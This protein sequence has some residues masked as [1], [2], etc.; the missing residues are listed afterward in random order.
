MPA[1]RRSLLS[2]RKKK[3]LLPLLLLPSWGLFRTRF[4]RRTDME[5]V[6]FPISNEKVVIFN[7]TLSKSKLLK[8]NQP[9]VTTILQPLI[10]YEPSP[11]E[12]TREAT[13]NQKSSH[14]RHRP[15]MRQHP[16]LFEISNA[17]S[18]ADPPPAPTSIESTHSSTFIRR[19]LKILAPSS[20]RP[21]DN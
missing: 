20:S 8:T 5:K 17:L 7:E 21:I 13:N 15:E 11:P 10:G 2:S 19:G 3:T 6:C 9:T 4:I 12:Q 1:I 18:K 14:L 16:H